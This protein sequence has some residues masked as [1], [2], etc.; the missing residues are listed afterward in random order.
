MKALKLLF[1]C[2]LLCQ[3][4]YAQTWTTL[5]IP[6]SGRFDDLFFLNDSVAWTCN[7]NG[8]TYKTTNGGQTWI[9]HPVSTGSYLRSIKFMDADTGFCGGLDFGDYLFKSTNGGQSW[10]NISN[11]VPG[12]QDGVCGLSCP[13]GKVIYGCG[14]F[15][16]PAYVIKSTDGGVSWQK[17]DLSAHALALVDILFLNA[18]E[19]WVSGRALQDA[20]GVILHTSDGGATWEQVA[21]SGVHGDYAWKMQR[22]DA[23]NWFAS[24]ER[25]ATA[26]AK[27]HM[28]KSTDSGL[29]WQTKL[30]SNTHSRT[31]AIGF[32]N[33]LHG[34]AGD[35]NLF[36]TLDGGQTWQNINT[37]LSIGSAFNRFVRISDKKAFLTGNRIYRFDG[38]SVATQAPEKPGEHDEIH[39]L[40]ISPNP[41]SDQFQISIT[42]RQKTLVILKIYAFNGGFEELLWTGEQAAGDY[43]LQSS[44]AHLPDGNY[45]VYLKTN[46]GTQTK[47]VTKRS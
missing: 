42:L 3:Q 13:G 38:I 27:T 31:Q 43:L 14:V 23:Q 7:G 26:G 8:Q 47:M 25:D 5:N 12:L 24:I 22:L 16:A 40:S 41:S 39:R 15:A 28:F 46:H 30:I 33:P 32:I 10:T 11:K 44:L 20:G 37:N 4:A 6:A 35:Y 9:N 34:W 1:C 17:I 21:H 29:N 19:G 2:A 36:E 18:Q 45:V